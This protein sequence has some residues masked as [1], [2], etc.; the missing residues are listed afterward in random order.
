MGGNYAEYRKGIIERIGQKQVD[1]LENNN[2]VR[3][4]TKDEL[5]EIKTRYNRRYVEKKRE[6]EHV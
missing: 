2:A 4:Y 5:R 6:N 1:Q 3:R